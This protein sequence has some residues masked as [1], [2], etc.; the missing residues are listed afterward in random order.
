[1]YPWL[2]ADNPRIG[3]AWKGV[4]ENHQNT[5]SLESKAVRAL[6]VMNIRSSSLLPLP[7]STPPFGGKGDTNELV[8]LP[9]SHR[10]YALIPFSLEPSR[11]SLAETFFQVAA[12]F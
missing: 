10:P 1:M 6:R 8:S 7:M 11:L 9:H 2:E 4:G 3:V 12:L 5:R